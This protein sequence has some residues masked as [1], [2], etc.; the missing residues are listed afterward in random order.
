MNFTCKIFQSVNVVGLG[1]CNNN[2]CELFTCNTAALVHKII[3]LFCSK[4]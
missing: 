4:R 3:I 2:Y 1:N